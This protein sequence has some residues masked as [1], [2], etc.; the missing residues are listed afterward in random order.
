MGGYFF[1]TIIYALRSHNLLMVAFLALFVVG[2]WYSGLMSLLQGRF[3]WLFRRGEPSPAKPFPAVGSYSA[4]LEAGK[5]TAPVI[6][7]TLGIPN[8]SK[9]TPVAAHSELPFV[10][11][12][13]LSQ[14]KPRL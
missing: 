13:P 5:V 8:N 10:S 1:V 7:R 6:D 11:F 3:E 9:M 14:S 2:Y 4:S 12:L